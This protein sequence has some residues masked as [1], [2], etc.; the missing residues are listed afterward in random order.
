VR[1]SLC[2]SA[3]CISSLLAVVAPANADS[4]F[5]STGSPDGRMASASRPD[6]PGNFEIET[7]DDFVV[8]NPTS[9][10]SATFT[11]LIP[12]NSSLSSINSV[13]V[14]I[15]KVFPLDSTVPPSNRVPTRTN[16]PS[17]NAFFALSSTN[18]GLSFT[19]T[20]LLSSFTANNSVQPGGIHPVPGQHT[21]GDGS[22]T[23]Q[24]VQFGVTFATPFNL[25]ADH[26]FFVPQVQLA[27]GNF[28]WLSAPRPIVTPG[29]PFPSGFT[30]LQGWARDANLDP[31]WLRVGQDIVG[32][33]PFPTFNFA[34]SVSGVAV[35]G[36]VAGAGLPGLLAG[37]GAML[38]WYRRRRAAAI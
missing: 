27:D 34:F 30:D 9:I 6:S 17:D 8:T 38:A 11:G 28:L 1:F 24:E 19:G 21:G 33:D 4:Y 12:T 16:S 31:D 7:A 10:T 14:E 32:G 13:T 22:V 26:Y 15:Y 3:V 35:P 2:V 36:P 20:L 29:T 18:N 23:G 25:P 37:F 5:F